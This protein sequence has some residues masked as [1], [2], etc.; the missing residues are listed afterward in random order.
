MLQDGGSSVSSEYTCPGEEEH[1][2]WGGTD[3]S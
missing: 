3:S 1:G 2:L